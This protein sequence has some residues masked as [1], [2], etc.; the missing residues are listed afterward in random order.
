VGIDD[1]VS[2]IRQ[3]TSTQYVHCEMLIPYDKGNIVSYPILMIMQ[4]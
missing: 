4:R 1:L 2:A 3:K